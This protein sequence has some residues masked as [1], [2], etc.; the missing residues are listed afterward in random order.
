MSDMCAGV[1]VVPD[2]VTTVI[3]LCHVMGCY[4]HTD[5]HDRGMQLHSLD[6]T[7]H[8]VSLRRFNS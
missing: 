3:I 8:L 5:I 6:N 4:A 2:H 7:Y 1:G